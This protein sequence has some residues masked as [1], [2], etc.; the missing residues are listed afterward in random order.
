MKNK[1]IF[2]L[3]IGSFSD[4]LATVQTSKGEQDEG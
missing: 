3:Y 1:L 4:N 2:L